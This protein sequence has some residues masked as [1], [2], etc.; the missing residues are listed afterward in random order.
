MEV[1][2]PNKRMCMHGDG[3]PTVIR[4]GVRGRRPTYLS[5]SNDSILLDKHRQR[6]Q[7]HNIP[8]T[9]RQLL[10]KSEASKLSTPVLDKLP[11][12]LQCLPFGV[13]STED[14]ERRCAVAIGD[15]AIDLAKYAQSGRL[16]DVSDGDKSD[17]DF[18]HVFKQ[19]S[20]VVVLKKSIGI[21]D[22]PDKTDNL[23]E[24]ID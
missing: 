15:H 10:W 23:E 21:Q 2:A 11:F 4:P 13:I 20:I 5:F 9:R 17:T 6:L 12:T 3:A 16:A 18:E 7:S 22:P 8:Q 14:S 19:V 24:I 1:K